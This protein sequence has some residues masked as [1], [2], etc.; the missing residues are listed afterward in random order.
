MSTLQQK[1]VLPDET[2]ETHT[3]CAH[4]PLPGTSLQ[5]LQESIQQSK[6]TQKSQ[7]HLP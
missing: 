7:E 3:E 1:S 4:A 6:L 2:E 5:H